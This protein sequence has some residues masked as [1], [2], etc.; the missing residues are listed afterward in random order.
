MSKTASRFIPSGRSRHRSASAFVLALVLA[1]SLV[2]APG[3]S[4]A[5]RSTG[6]LLT[7]AARS[8]PTYTDITANKARNN[9]ME[10]LRD[11]GPDTPYKSGEN[12]DP[13]V[14]EQV[15]PSCEPLPGW[16]FTL[17]N[18]HT[19]KAVSG[20]WGV[21]SIIK[22]QLREPL[23]TKKETPLLNAQGE[24]TGK[25]IAGA[26]TFE[27]GA[28]EAALAPRGA[29]WVQ[30]GTPADPILDQLFPGPE[31][32][33]GALR[34]A[35]DNVNGDNVE[36]VSYPAGTTH[37]FCFAYY[38][39]PP[40]TGGT[41]VI[42][43]RTS[44]AGAPAETFHFGGNL[45][46]N[47]GGRF[48]LSPA[49]GGTASETFY[50]GATTAGEGPWR[51]TE[52]GAVDWRLADLSCDSRDGT[53]HVDTSTKDGEATI[54][55][56]P[57]DL[58]TCTYT[59]EYSPPPQGLVIRKVTEG[60]IGKFDFSVDP[61]GGGAHKEAT[62]TTDREGVAVDASPSPLDLDP[63]RYRIAERLP[64][65]KAGEW[66]L[67][68]VQCDGHQV[69]LED[70]AVEV[71]IVARQ[72]ETCTFTN[73][74]VPAGSI[75]ISKITRGA[76]GTTGFEIESDADPE[77][78]LRQQATTT[79]SGDPVKAHGDPSDHLKLGGYT[80]TE[81]PPAPHKGEWEL[82]EVKCDGV[83]VPFAEGRVEVKLTTKDPHRHCAFVNEFHAK[84]EPPAPGPPEGEKP[85]HLVIEKRLVTKQPEASSLLEYEITVKNTG[86]G[87]S[88]D[89]TVVDQP[90]GSARLV[91][92]R[93][94]VG[95][96]GESLPVRC[97]LGTLAAGATA[98]IRVG[99]ISPRP[100]ELTNRAIAGT[101]S[102]EQ[103]VA[104]AEAE[105]PAK[106][107]PSRPTEPPVP[108]LG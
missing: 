84:A 72:V 35:T 46:Y 28:D 38:V 1:L 34:C 41:I 77:T 30:G 97:E 22:G 24:A 65:S 26:V 70:D 39:K 62:A 106:L 53:S 78:T 93:P 59:N 48:S 56:A 23:T 104:G 88:Y 20:P 63:G 11:L 18:S 60:G 49:A 98:T 94:S 17:G 85:A 54:H 107:K 8:C 5:P 102:A 103:G 101:A 75:S 73:R 92:A 58:V 69:P 50:R 87:D 37:V 29:L 2:A 80:I 76:V 83:I 64:G 27:L 52:E 44:G 51:V 4:A 45:S 21:L 13:E 86:P 7:L 96:C 15:Q 91:F 55:L 61:A 42:R 33:F 43:K 3:G 79:T 12:V 100:G 14:E 16:E 25:Q 31:Y 95:T 47:P 57:E 9:I 19:S 105:A 81:S 89:T 10:S 74:F 82:V 32:G 99:I 71:T 36:Y 40:P 90:L 68:E 67:A 6:L 108:G 66:K